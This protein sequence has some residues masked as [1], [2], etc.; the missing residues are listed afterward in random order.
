[1]ED[2]GKPHTEIFETFDENP[3]AAASLAQ[4]WFFICYYFVFK[5]YAEWS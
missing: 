4:V 5:N 3:V 1:M 2:F